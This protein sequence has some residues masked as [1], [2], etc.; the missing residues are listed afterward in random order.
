M[1][2]A[3][4]PHALDKRKSPEDA[5]VSRAIARQPSSCRKGTRNQG[6]C[7]R[8][9]TLSVPQALHEPT[10]TCAN[11]LSSSFSHPD[12]TVGS[13]LTPD[14]ALCRT[15]RSQR[16]AGLRVRRDHRR[17]GISPCPEGIAKFHRAYYTAAVFSLTIAYDPAP[18]YLRTPQFHTLKPIKKKI[19]PIKGVSIA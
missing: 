6:L 7:L 8:K 4:S 19:K 16:L 5:A 15:V 17:S 14:P 2:T 1:A 9:T 18:L 11:V 12:C 13:G 10:S 3:V